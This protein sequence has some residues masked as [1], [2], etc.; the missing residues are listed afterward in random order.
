M[1]EPPNGSEGIRC[2]GAYGACLPRRI[3]GDLLGEGAT[4]P[5]LRKLRDALLG[6]PMGGRA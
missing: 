6:G 2:G 4:G 5:K 3:K 1:R